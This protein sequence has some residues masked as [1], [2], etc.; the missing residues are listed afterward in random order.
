MA[1]GTGNVPANGTFTITQVITLDCTPG[2]SNSY[3][4]RA[5]ASNSCG[6][7]GPVSSEP[8]VVQCKSLPEVSVRCETST[9]TA[10]ADADI[11]ITGFARNDGDRPADILLTVHGTSQ[12]FPGVAAGAERADRAVRTRIVAGATVGGVRRD[13]GASGAAPQ[14]AARAVAAGRL[15]RLADRALDTARA[16][17][18]RART[19]VDATFRT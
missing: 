16:A 8:C 6:E 5:T 2:G 17:A 12:N 10:P 19:E 3:S 11:T 18:R 1:T 9:Q 7:V 15:A 14:Q 13:L 4:A